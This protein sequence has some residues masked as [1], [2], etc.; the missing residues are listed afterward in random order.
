MATI[1]FSTDSRFL[2]DVQDEALRYARKEYSFWASEDDCRMM[3]QDSMFTVFNK[4]HNGT[5]TELTC[6]L[7]TYVIGIL[8][9][10]AKKQASKKAKEPILFL[11]QSDDD[12]VSDP[13]DIAMI[14]MVLERWQDEENDEFQ[15][16]LQEE[17]RRLVQN[18]KEPCRSILWA[19]YWE[20]KKMKEIAEEQ[21]YSGK[22]V[23][24]SQK[25][26]CMTKVKTAMEEI[27]QQL[28]S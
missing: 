23:A 9:K 3:V 24:K 11:E 18:M 19:Y 16:Q 7:K 17:V 10:I 22:D 26:R 28:R 8:K 4:V 12:D 20:G 5:L 27:Y 25:S 2:Q 15:E 13:I 14:P 1:P 21:N 6:S